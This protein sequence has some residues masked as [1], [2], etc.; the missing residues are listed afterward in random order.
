VDFTKDQTGVECGALS[1][2]L[3]VKEKVKTGFD[4]NREL[5]ALNCTYCDEQFHNV[6]RKSQ[7][8][9]HFGSQ[10]GKKKRIK[11]FMCSSFE[12]LDD[13]IL[14]GYSDRMETGSGVPKRQDSLSTGALGGA[15]A[16][17]GDDSAKEPEH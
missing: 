12:G 14:T 9:E 6:A 5:K 7:I 13:R 2:K 11:A 1:L 15:G 8:D 16:N 17:I 4:W 3:L 10:T